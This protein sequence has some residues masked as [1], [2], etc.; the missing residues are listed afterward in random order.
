MN[1]TISKLPQEFHL[2]AF[3]IS[4]DYQLLLFSGVLLIYS[5]AIIGNVAI[6]SIVCF[7]SQLHTPMYAFICNLSVQ[8][9][10]YV[11]VILPKLLTITISG[12]PSISGIF[13][14]TQEYLFTFCIETEFLLLSFMSYD[15]YVAICLPLRYC[16]I[17]NNK[18]CALLASTA[19]VIAAI[20]SLQL[21]LLISDSSFCKS[22]EINHFFC[23]LKAILKLSCS[24]TTN[25][26][27]MIF[28]QGTIIGVLPFLLILT[29]YAIIICNIMQIRTSAG[30]VKAFSS[31]SSHLTVVLL[32]CGTSLSLYMIPE[33]THS[34]EQDK[35]LSLLYVA[36]VPMLNPLVYSLRNKEVLTAFKNLY[37]FLKGKLSNT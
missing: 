29:S 11:S 24:D 30:K 13:C 2:L 4:A 3:S 9:I 18:T 7:V 15:R 33:A 36:V 17:M 20:D 26:K 12:D 6:I 23:D 1:T 14:I 28:I 16:T 5:L 32:F 10:L 19:W 21:S 31:C 8:D 34:E 35:L 37:I 22:K 25:I 27:N